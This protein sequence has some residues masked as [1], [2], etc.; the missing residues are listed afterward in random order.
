MYLEGRGGGAKS[1]GLCV[2]SS[3]S[4]FVFFHSGG[5]VPS[6]GLGKHLTIFVRCFEAR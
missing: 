4:V 1:G 6:V 2:T 3:S 5:V